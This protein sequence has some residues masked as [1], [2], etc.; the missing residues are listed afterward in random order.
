MKKY[1][2]EQGYTL[3][4]TVVAMGLFVGVLLPL[5]GSMGSLFLDRKTE[6]MS[7]A[8]Q[9]AE[10]EITEISIQRDFTSGA[11]KEEEG[12]VVTRKIT[13]GA[14]SFDVEVAVASSRKIDAPLV[15]LT[16][17]ILIR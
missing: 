4:E 14:F 12:F 8:L 15:L 3:V 2:D 1:Q 9:L 5:S 11:R 7:R 13:K 17:T 10:S 6:S 16:K